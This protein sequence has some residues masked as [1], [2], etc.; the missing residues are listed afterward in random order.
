MPF[1]ASATPDALQ[2]EQLKKG[3]KETYEKLN[4]LD[5]DLM[6]HVDPGDVDKEIE[7]SE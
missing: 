4:K 6:P 2:L 3:L 5:E 7:D 1:T